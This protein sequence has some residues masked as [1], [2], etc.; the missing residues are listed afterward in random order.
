M[1][2]LSGGGRT[3][4]V[5]AAVDPTIGCSFPVAGTIPRYL[6]SGGS[7]GD[8]EQNEPSFYRLAGYLDLY[9]LGAVGAGCAQGT[10]TRR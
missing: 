3:T 9:L 6:R 7:V 8:R 10:S 4:T 5:Y 1:I 2:G